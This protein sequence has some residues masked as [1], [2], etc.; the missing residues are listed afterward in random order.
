MLDRTESDIVIDAQAG[1][2]VAFEKLVRRYQ[3]LITS[4]AYSRTGD[5]QR[6]E[7][8]AQQAFITAWEKRKDLKDP[9]RFGGWLSSITRNITLNSNRKAN[10]H[11]RT[12]GEL[13]GHQEPV[14]TV[15]PE[16]SMATEEQRQLL[17]ASLKNIPEEYREPLILYYREEKSVAQVAELM[18]LS[19][20]A[21]KQR[22]AR[23]RAM[24]KSEVEQFVEDLLGSS[25]PRASFVSAVMVAIPT[26]SG[27]AI[28]AVIQGST[29]IGAKTML[30]KL[31]LLASGP[32]LGALG[33]I[34][35]AAGGIAGGYYGTKMSVK[36]ATSEEEKNLLWKFFWMILAQTVVFTAVSV[37]GALLLEP[38][39]SIL[40][41]VLSA[42][43]VYTIIL[44][45]QIVVFINKQK[46][47]HQTH[48]RP[49]YPSEVGTGKPASLKEFR[50]SIIGATIG[51]WTWLI[52]MS[53]TQ[54]NWIVF[55]VS[56]VVMLGH[57]T[58]RFGG[59]GYPKTLADQLR[60]Q[61]IMVLVNTF[62][63]GAIFM[64]AEFVGLT[65]KPLP[66]WTISLF[67]VLVGWACAAGIW[68][69]AIRAEQKAAEAEASN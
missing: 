55:G 27:P 64:G 9:S 34:L 6:S 30:G 14:A 38:G 43:A 4:I 40:I 33:G 49:D 48:G 66:N 57:F 50:L 29:T 22:L 15:E 68:Y 2:T 24:L 28:K 65:Y 7:D 46:A 17:W 5:L 26:A 53:L 42:T 13:Q 44:C 23:G 63:S 1:N 56:L 52:V 18:G 54:L 32:I 59:A 41:F 31:G 36:Y 8:I 25:K 60:L 11:D 37:A 67:V 47:L 21:V 12:T 19:V 51:C 61:A 35:G 20:D 39:P 62:L 45:V 58:W 16:Q 10:R 3:N 69:A